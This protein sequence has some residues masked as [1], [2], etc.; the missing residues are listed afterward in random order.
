MKGL[1]HLKQRT[2]VLEQDIET[3]K[4]SVETDE[5]EETPTEDVTAIFFRTRPSRGVFYNHLCEQEEE[6]TFEC[7]LCT[8]QVAEPRTRKANISPSVN[9]VPQVANQGLEA[10]K[11]PKFLPRLDNSMPNTNPNANS[12]KARRTNT[13]RSPVPTAVVETPSAQRDATNEELSLIKQAEEAVTIREKE[14]EA[15]SKDRK[16][17]IQSLKAP[18]ID[19]I[20][21]DVS[22]MLVGSALGIGVVTFIFRS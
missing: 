22:A 10:N 18:T 16:K 6:T 3:Q 4:K 5:A 7:P 15:E 9:V 12:P 11:M 19:Q 20:W 21:S 1:E 17:R 8:G 2:I 13:G 14:S